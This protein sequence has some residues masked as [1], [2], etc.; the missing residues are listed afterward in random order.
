[1]LKRSFAINSVPFPDLAHYHQIDV[2][3]MAAPMLTSG[4]IKDLSSKEICRALGLEEEPMPHSA[5]NGALQAK[6]MYEALLERNNQNNGEPC[7][8]LSKSALNMFDA[9]AKNFAKGKTSKP[10]N[11]KKLSRLLDANN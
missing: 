1:M 5:L 10:I 6:K 7:V 3:S 4:E 11:L 2:G 9:S 8:E